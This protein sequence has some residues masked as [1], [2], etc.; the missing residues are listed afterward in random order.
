M[1]FNNIFGR[2]PLDG[3]VIPFRKKHVVGREAFDWNHDIEEG[4]MEHRK[5]LDLY[6]MDKEELSIVVDHPAIH[7]EVRLYAKLELRLLQLRAFEDR[8]GLDGKTIP[9]DRATRAHLEH[10]LAEI[11]RKQ[12]YLYFVRIPD[13]LK[14]KRPRP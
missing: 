11:H 4:E 7:P 8:K 1:D 14:W 9:L 6:N 2:S 3:D 12:E 5:P 13:A 10:E